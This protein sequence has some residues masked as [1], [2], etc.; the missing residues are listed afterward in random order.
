MEE[1]EVLNRWQQYVGDLCR[2]SNRR[3][4]EVEKSEEGP[5]ILRTEV[6][7]AVRHMKWR[8]SEGSDGIMV[9]MVEAAGNIAKTKI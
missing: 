5:G 8:K 2:D 3:I 9:E 4:M 6:E 1:G 7:E